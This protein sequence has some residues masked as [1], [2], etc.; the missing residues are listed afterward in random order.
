VVVKKSVRNLILYP[1]AILCL[2]PLMVFKGHIYLMILYLFVWANIVLALAVF[3]DE[4]FDLP[5]KR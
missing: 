3:L 4:L 1:V 2:Y 5:R